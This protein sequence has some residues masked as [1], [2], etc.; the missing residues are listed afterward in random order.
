MSTRQ[1]TFIAE[2]RAA[3]Q[4]IWEAHQALKALKAEADA[5][6]YG[7]TLIAPETGPDKD[8]ILALPYATNDA[9]AT[10]LATGHASN[11]AK[12]L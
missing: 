10:L 6:D 4:S 2:V 8:D 7:N 1:D 12:L 11:I 3:A 5:L 9:I